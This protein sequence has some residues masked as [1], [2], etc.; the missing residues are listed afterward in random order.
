MRLLIKQRVFSW[1]DTYDVYDENE[2]AKY[3]V[4]A[5]DPP[6]INQKLVY[7]VRKN[8]PNLEIIVRAKNRSYAYNYLKN[9][10]SEVYRENF[11]S[12]VYVGRQILMKYGFSYEEASKIGEIFIKSDRKSL[13]KIAKHAENSD[14]YF[15]SSKE[16][17]EKQMKMVAKEINNRNHADNE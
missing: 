8:F 2:N 1:T 12:S 10:L 15:A 14:E 17:F 11:F 3:F 6:E 5:L 7:I 9:G 16:E 13:L 4:A